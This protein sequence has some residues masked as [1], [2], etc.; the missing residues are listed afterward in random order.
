MDDNEQDNLI[1]PITQEIFNEPVICEDGHT[2]EKDAILEWFKHNDTSPI[3]RLVIA[4]K[5]TTNYALKKIVNDYKLKSN[6]Q[7]SVKSIRYEKEYEDFREQEEYEEPQTKISY[8]DI[9]FTNL[10]DYEIIRTLNNGHKF[11]IIYEHLSINIF[12]NNTIMKLIID[13]TIDLENEDQYGYR[14]IHY[15]CQYSTP[16]MI[17]YII[18]KGVNLESKTNEGMRPIHL[19]CRFSTQEIIDYILSKGVN[20]EC[21]TNNDYDI[22]FMYDLN[23]N[24]EKNVK[25]IYFKENY[26]HKGS[27]AD[28]CIIS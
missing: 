14:P 9:N 12:K 27:I 6:N 28:R 18:D 23:I 22:Q 4:R 7:I 19:I 13:K 26:K 24:R 1:C 17:K 21:L 2:Y 10:S 25:T 3:T 16:E 8:L 20:H 15:I 11:Y 5:F